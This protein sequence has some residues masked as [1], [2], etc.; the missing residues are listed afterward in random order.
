MTLINSGNQCNRKAEWRIH[1]L[2]VKSCFMDMAA[3]Y[4]MQ[5]KLGNVG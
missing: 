1:Y 3:F 2:Y 4:I 5:W